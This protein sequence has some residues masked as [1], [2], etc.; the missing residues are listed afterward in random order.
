[1]GVCPS[2]GTLVGEYK[3]KKGGNIKKIHSTKSF[4]P[5]YSRISKKS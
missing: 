2:P 5:D 1:M 4:Y 3:F